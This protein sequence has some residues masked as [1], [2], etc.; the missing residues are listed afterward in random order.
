M[1]ESRPQITVPGGSVFRGDLN[2]GWD[3]AGNADDRVLAELLRLAPFDGTNITRGIVP[4]GLQVPGPAN[5]TIAPAVGGVTVNPFRAVVGSRTALLTDTKKNWQ[6]IVSAVAVNSTTTLAFSVPLAANPTNYR[7]DLI[8]ATLTPDVAAATTL[9]KVKGPLDGVVTT[10]SVSVDRGPT[11]TISV[12]TGTPAVAASV[13]RPALPADPVGGYNIEL[14]SVLLTPGHTAASAMNAY[15][16]HESAY[17]LRRRGAEDIGSTKNRVT[18]ATASTW[19][20]LVAANGQDLRVDSYCPSSWA[21][22]ERLVFWHQFAAATTSF[23]ID[24]SRDWRN[25]IF[26]ISAQILNGS[27]K[28]AQGSN[29]LSYLN[30]VPRAS[31]NVF[32]ESAETNRFVLGGNGGQRHHMWH[33]NSLN[34]G[35]ATVTPDGNYPLFSAGAGDVNGVPAGNTI[36]LYVSSSDGTLRASKSGTDPIYG[37]FWLEASEPMPNKL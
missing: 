36:G 21:G 20:T 31:D 29:A 12:V 8:Y 18:D 10:Q 26:R 14:G 19:A 16:I 35:Y 37:F 13:V 27:F 5:A 22:I 7:W 11:V 9:R 32:G 4:Y 2:E 23:V 34:I 24:S 28:A 3:V 15:R 17:V 33:A 30:G 6:D 1:A 25:R